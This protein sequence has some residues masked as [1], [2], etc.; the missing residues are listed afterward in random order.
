MFTRTDD[1]VY[2]NTTYKNSMKRTETKLL[3][4]NGCPPIEATYVVNKT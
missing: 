2:C 1:V 3:T 4:K